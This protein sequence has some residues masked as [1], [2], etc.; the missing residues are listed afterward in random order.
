MRAALSILGLVIVLALV[1]QQ[2]KRSASTLAP[3]KPAASAAD[4]A[5]APAAATEA[6][7]Q[8]VQ[9]ALDHGAQRASEAQP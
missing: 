2:M 8:Q 5:Q 9:G 6:V 3:P 1:L 4:A 7:R